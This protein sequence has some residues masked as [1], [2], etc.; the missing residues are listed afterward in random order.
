[1]YP[2]RSCGGDRR[3]RLDPRLRR[4]RRPRVAGRRHDRR[5]REH[6]F[7]ML[8]RKRL[9]DHPA[10]RRAD[11]VRGLDPERIEQPGRIAGHVGER[12][13]AGRDLARERT[14]HRAGRSVGEDRRASR[15]AVV[16][17]DDAEALSGDQLAELVRPQDHLRAEAHDHEQRRI[18]RLARTA[19]ST[20][21]A[22]PPGR[23]AP[24]RKA[25][26]PSIAA[27]AGRAVSVARRAVAGKRTRGDHRRSSSRVVLDLLRDLAL[28]LL[29]LRV[30]EL[31]G[32]SP[33]VLAPACA[34]ARGPA[35]SSSGTNGEFE[36]SIAGS[37]RSRTSVD[38]VLVA[39]IERAVRHVV[40]GLP[41]R[42]RS[43]VSSPSEASTN[44]MSFWTC[45]LIPRSMSC[46]APVSSRSA[47]SKAICHASATSSPRLPGLGGA[48]VDVGEERVLGV[49]IVRVDEVV[50]DEARLDVREDLLR[51]H[52]VRG[53]EHR[54]VV[55][56]PA[57]RAPRAGAGSGCGC[58]PAWASRRSRPDRAAGS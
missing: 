27:R 16:E 3:Q 42:C 57:C 58:S 50:L 15:I 44:G 43:V 35:R 28:L 12:V 2:S 17:A 26:G 21:R 34:P 23:T 48:E 41:G 51:E 33:D 36:R 39:A 7:R 11:D 40:V 29:A 19:A 25:R 46:T 24:R 30:E 37:K 56:A 38:H 14:R 53:R 6:A 31:L 8:D 9:G 4:A 45:A 5:Q 55:A 52:E 20:A 13:R 18:A 32:V 10:E 54:A 49:E 22:R 47:V 1:M